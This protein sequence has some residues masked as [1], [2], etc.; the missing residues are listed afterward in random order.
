MFTF[1][2]SEELSGMTWCLRF[3]ADAFTTWKDA[4]TIHLWEGKNRS[5]YAKAK[6][7][8]QKYIQNAYEDIE[9]EDPDPS[10][11]L[12]E[13]EEEEEQG[14]DGNEDED[15][16]SE[17]TSMPGDAVFSQGTKNEQLAV[18]YKDDL[19]FVTRGSMIGVFAHKDDRFQFRAAIDRVKDIEGRTFTPKK[20]SCTAQPSLTYQVMLHNQDQN[21][22]MLDPN[23]RNSVMRM[24]LE[25]GKV[26]DEWKVSDDIS[27]DNILPEY[28]A[29]MACA[30]A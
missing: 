2:E 12:D 6:A 11:E 8:E 16:D 24:D 22:L 4:F 25:Y 21:M 28:V 1:R 5:S 29:K 23:H 17:D 10:E 26:V 3:G 7:D 14:S 19:S 9:M 13:E 30:D 20:V 15:K 18:G 27:V